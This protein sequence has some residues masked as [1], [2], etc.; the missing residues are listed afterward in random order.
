MDWLVDSGGCGKTPHPKY[1][2]KRIDLSIGGV[3]M[4]YAVFLIIFVFVFVPLR[5]L[6]IKFF[7]GGR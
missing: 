4:K 5:R 1:K 6:F 3:K 2:A 7:N